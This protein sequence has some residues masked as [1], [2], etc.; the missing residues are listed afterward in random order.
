MGYM[1]GALDFVRD[2]E[3]L[4]I[5]GVRFV[6]RGDGVGGHELSSPRRGES[7]S[8]AIDAFPQ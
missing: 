2:G 8:D 3:S 5:V 6:R 7:A 1:C 4:A